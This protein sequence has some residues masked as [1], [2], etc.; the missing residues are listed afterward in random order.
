MKCA[1]CR[2]L[3]RMSFNCK[4]HSCSHSR[5]GREFSGPIPISHSSACIDGY[6][7]LKLDTARIVV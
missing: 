3:L 6:V 1:T 4:S 7:A 5:I 2:K